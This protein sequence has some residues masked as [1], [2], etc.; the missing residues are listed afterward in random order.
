MRVL[1]QG[2]MIGIDEVSDARIAF[3]ESTILSRRRTTSVFAA[4]SSTIASVGQRVEVGD[5][6]NTVEYVVRRG[7]LAT[8]LGTFEGGAKAVE[9]SLGRVVA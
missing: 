1:V 2:F 6:L 7:E 5:D 4:S 9:P 3:G 8:Y